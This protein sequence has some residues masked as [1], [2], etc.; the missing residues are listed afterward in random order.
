VIPPRESAAFVWRME[1]VLDLHEEPYDEQRPVVCFDER[2]CQLLAD[3]REPLPARPG[4]PGAARG[5][6][7][8]R[9]GGA[10]RPTRTCP[11]SP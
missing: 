2:P 7:T 4:G 1:T 6:W 8:T 5:L 3:V 10:A 11:S 9:I